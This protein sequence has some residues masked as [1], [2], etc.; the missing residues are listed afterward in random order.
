MKL[1]N[2]LSN[3]LLKHEGKSKSNALAGSRLAGFDK[4]PNMMSLS[5][6][7]NNFV[8]IIQDNTRPTP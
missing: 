7:Y 6:S 1:Q 2:I 5:V 3:T 8:V 4:L